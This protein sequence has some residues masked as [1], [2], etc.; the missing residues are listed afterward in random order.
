M[1]NQNKDINKSHPKPSDDAQSL[2]E[3]IIPSSQTKESK[4]TE[5]KPVAGEKVEQKKEAQ[6]VEK[7]NEVAAKPE[8]DDTADEQVEETDAKEEKKQDDQGDKIETVAP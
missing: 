4:T 3:T 6:E 1:E 7:E 2:V 5:I 8:I